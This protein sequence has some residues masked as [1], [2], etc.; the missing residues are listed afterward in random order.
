MT[1]QKATG[2]DEARLDAVA[3]I[4]SAPTIT[5]AAESLGV[6]R[7]TVYAW[8]EDAALQAAITDARRR[9]FEAALSRLQ[10]VLGEVTGEVLAMARDTSNK[11]EVRLSAY[12][13]L[14]DA[15]FRAHDAIGTTERIRELEDAMTQLRS[16][17][18]ARS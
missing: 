14:M 4:L 11:P 18:E 8:L 5:A 3:A 7:S 1:R 12:G 2:S 17:I 13:K 10:A 15:T 16:E 6:A 9:A